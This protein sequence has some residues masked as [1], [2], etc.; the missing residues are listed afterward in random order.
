MSE[1]NKINEKEILLAINLEDLNKVLG[2]LGRIPYAQVYQAFNIL[3]NLK[4]IDTSGANKVMSL[5][6][7]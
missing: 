7:E 1:E 3:T 6:L 5:P 4:Q 2:L